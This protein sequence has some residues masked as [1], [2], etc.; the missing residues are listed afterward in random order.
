MKK[1]LLVFALLLGVTTAWSQDSNFRFG[2]K[3]QP[4]L[5]WFRVDAPDDTHI[6]SDG[7]P[8]G[9]GF[10]LITDFSFTDRYAFSTGLEISNRPGKLVQT[11]STPTGNMTVRQKLSLRFVE[12]PLTLKM[13]TNEIGYITYFFQA[14]LSPGYA[15]RSRAEIEVNDNV[16]DD[17]KDISSAINEFNLSMILGVGA[18]YSLGGSTSLLIGITYNNGFLDLLDDDAYGHDVKGNSNYVALALGVMF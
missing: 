1:A 6:E 14:G 9:F 5:A 8:F 16:T 11:E 2:V 15:I 4:S 18:E 3:A 12:I 7:M 10:G 13:R 17:N